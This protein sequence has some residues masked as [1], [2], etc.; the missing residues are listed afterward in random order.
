AAWSL[1]LAAGSQVLEC[2]REPDRRVRGP[3]RR[4]VGSRVEGEGVRHPGPIQLAVELLV[5]RAEAFV[6][7]SN[8]E[9]EEGRQ[10]AERPLECGNERVRALRRSVRQDAGAG[11]VRGPEVAAPGF[12][13]R[14]RVEP[15]QTEENGA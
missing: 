11:R 4:R 14:E 10:P 5:L 9:G 3:G 7:T 12:D 2:E 13:H 15:V 8:V 1:W 6:F